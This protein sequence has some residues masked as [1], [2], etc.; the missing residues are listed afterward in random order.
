MMGD[1]FGKTLAQLQHVMDYRMTRQGVITSNIANVDTPGYRAK[2][3]RFE[4]TFEDQLH[5]ATTN[6]GH[7]QPA[8]AA[9]YHSVVDDPF[10]RLGNDGNTVDIDRE[11]MKLTQNQFLY[12]ASAQTVENK[13][14]ALKEII[15]GIR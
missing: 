4:D 8:A 13:L 15:K 12:D 6:P 10:S 11:M 2:D 7:R 5:L 9:A 1:I 14:N 3:V